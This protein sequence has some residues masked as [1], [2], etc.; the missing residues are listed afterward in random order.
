[1]DGY[2]EEISESQIKGQK[3]S[4]VRFKGNKTIEEV[5]NVNKER[6]ENNT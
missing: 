4:Y 3:G 1:M 5:K 6:N 2:I